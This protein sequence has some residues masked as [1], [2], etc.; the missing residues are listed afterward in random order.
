MAIEPAINY[1]INCGVATTSAFVRQF[2]KQTVA[3]RT[4]NLEFFIEYKQIT[5]GSSVSVTLGDIN[6]NRNTYP[7]SATNIR[8]FV[9][10]LP[11]KFSVVD[12]IQSRNTSVL[13]NPTSSDPLLFEYQNNGTTQITAKFNT[14]EKITKSVSTFTVA[15]SSTQDVFLNFINGSIGRHIYDQIRQYADGSTSSPNHYPIYSTF[16]QTS[17]IYVKNQSHWTGNLNFSG[18]TVNKMGSGGVT[19]V[20]AITPHHAIGVAHYA[21]EVGDVLYF[22]DSNNQT[23]A[24]TVQSR[25]F[26]SNQ[27]CVIVRF[28]ETLPETVK[29]YKTLPS[30]FLNYFPINRNIYSVFG[31]ANTFRGAFMPAIVCSHYRWDSDW[32]L[33]RSNRYAYLYQTSFFS[34]G[35]F[36]ETI[37][38]GP[39]SSAPNSFPDYN[40]QPSGIRGGDSGSPCFFVINN[41]LVLVHCHTSGGGGPLHP[42]FLSSIQSTID[43][44]GPSGQT[45]ETVDISGFTDFSS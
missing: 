42:S 5:S 37:A 4:A 19:N 16:N 45:Y 23:V 11:E 22:C 44:L 41:D 25:Q 36:S 29:K 3:N 20:S 34:T 39:A 7:E 17:N 18:L 28:S 26:V 30:N 24:R 33:Q 2:S 38:F 15:E 12:S 35:L 14:N 21:P 43:T 1:P 10:Y 13:S 32:P 9:D 27:D 31:I 40:G 8:A 6:Y